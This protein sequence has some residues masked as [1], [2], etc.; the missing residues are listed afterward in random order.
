MNFILKTLAL[1]VISCLAAAIY[2]VSEHSTYA[3]SSGSPGNYTGSP[4]DNG[5]TCRSCH[6][7]PTAISIDDAIQPSIPVEGYTPGEVY[8]ITATIAESGRSMFGFELTAEDADQNKQ[9]Q[10]T[11]VNSNENRL[12]GGGTSVTHTTGGRNG[13]GTKEWT[14]QW[15]APETNVGAITFYAALMAANSSGGNSGDNVYVSQTEVQA[16]PVSIKEKVTKEKLDIAIYPN[17]AVHEIRLDLPEQLEE[18][19]GIYIL[20]AGGVVRAYYDRDQLHA[21]GTLSL[22][23]SSLASGSYFVKLFSGKYTATSPFIKS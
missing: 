8:N 23:V 14:V 6:S 7:G 17:P 15:Q 12:I 4:G 5:R 1:V 2:Q 19:F 22:N 16:K 18:D 21:A 3:F 10:F 20:D 9:G 13:N 11:V